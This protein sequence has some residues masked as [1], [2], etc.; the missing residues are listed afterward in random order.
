VLG[1]S[2]LNRLQR[3]TL[4][5]FVTVVA[6]WIIVSATGY[7]LLGGDLFTI[8]LVLFLILLALTL[9]RPIKQK[10]LWRV[11]NRLFVTY[12]LIGVL[13]LLL[14]LLIVAMLFS[15]TSG[16][17]L[18]YIAQSELSRNL[19]QL[20]QSAAQLALDV[21]AGRTRDAADF[22]VQAAVQTRNRLLATSGDIRQIPSWSKPGFK[23]IVATTRASYFLAAHSEAG[24]GEDRIEVFAYRAFDDRSVAAL[25]SGMGNMQVFRLRDLGDQSPQ[26]V[27]PVLDSGRITQ[28]QVPLFAAFGGFQ[29]TMVRMLDSGRSDHHGVYITTRPFL[30]FD[31]ILTSTLGSAKTAAI[32]AILIIVGMIVAVEFVAIGSSVKLTRTLTRAIHDLH[33]GTKKVESGDFSH[34]IPVRTKDQLNEL[35]TSFNNM[36]QRV[37]QLIVE[38]KEKEKLESELEIARQVQARLFP[39]EIP[40]LKTLELFGLCNPARVVS[41]D[42]YDFIQLDPR[43]TAI[44]IGDISGKGISAALLMAS[45]Q[46]A[47]HAQLTMG[48]NGGL[49]T[50]TLVARL[51]RQLYENTTPEKYATF[52]L[53]LYDDTSGLLAYTNAGHLAPIL[54]RNGSVLRLESNG[55]VVGMFPDFPY[56][57]QVV[58]LHAGDLLAAFTDG[59]TE[60]EDANGEQFGEQR[61]ADLLIRNQDRPLNE[62]VTAVTDS[63]RSWTSDFDNR[64]DTT[65]LLARRF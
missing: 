46:A 13:P 47:L 38:V 7:T 56:E 34:R 12:F 61:L 49:S 14:M 26:N 63:L 16:A 19:D 5:L 32:I 45:V 18:A 28:V 23:G 10:V 29:L 54:V 39:K 40:K 11:R 27:R 58:Q 57:Q 33:T 21:Q 1:F 64:D 2:R 22:P 50:A 55:M 48:T 24:A 62:I 35:A 31:R 4:I 59:I 3:I 30:V 8:L 43:C 36:T 6:N 17:T 52:Y 42:Y 37:E 65:I 15:A 20:E 51:N 44:V 60:S 9:I 25:V 53:G 41:G